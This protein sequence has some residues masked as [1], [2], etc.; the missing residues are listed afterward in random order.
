MG[1]ELPRQ[2]QDDL[3]QVSRMTALALGE[4]VVGHPR[5]LLAHLPHLCCQASGRSWSDVK[6]IQGAWAQLYDA[7]RLIDQ[8][9]DEDGLDLDSRSRVLTSSVALFFRSAETIGQLRPEI[10]SG[11]FAQIRQV[12]T[13]QWEDSINT[14]PTIEE[15]IRIAELKTGAFLGL[16]CWLGAMA[17]GAEQVTCEGFKDFGRS[18]GVLLQIHD[19]LEWLEGLGSTQKLGQERFSNVILAH[20]WQAMT[21]DERLKLE[22]SLIS[23]QSTNDPDAAQRIRE[24]LI[25]RG[26]RYVSALMGVRYRA[27]ALAALSR[28]QAPESEALQILKKLTE[29]LVKSFQ[30]PS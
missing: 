18:L 10:Q 1:D 13:G 16:G 25:R 6:S 14:H 17:A 27:L 21:T 3:T 11:L 29:T 22:S 12:V 9:Q 20:A 15:A 30:R 8:V 4:V 26:G 7:S 28:T 19:D 24:D 23:L 5:S 2:F